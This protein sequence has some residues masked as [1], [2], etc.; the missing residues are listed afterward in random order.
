MAFAPRRRRRRSRWVLVGVILSLVAL[1]VNAGVASR[2]DDP[3]KRLAELAYVDQ[4]H[5]HVEAS[6]LRGAEVN[7]VREDATELGRDGIRRKLE[8]VR[9][10]TATDL[11]AMRAIEPPPDL[12]AS[13]HL[14]VST[15]VLRARATSN[16]ASALSAVLGTIRPE[17]AVDEL[18]K[19]GEELI[20]ADHTY[21]VFVEL[22]VV[23][24]TR[25]PL[26]P[27]STW[28]SDRAAWERPAVS[29][30]VSALRASAMPTPVHDLSLLTF[31]TDPRPVAT[32]GAN[33]V[34]PLMKTLRVEVV[35]ANTGNAAEA[36]VPVVA[37]L[38]GPEGQLDTARQFVDLAPGQ[39]RAVALGGLRPVPGGPSNL[40]V[41]VGPVDGEG[42]LDDNQ[43]SM[44]LVLRG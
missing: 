42:G 5:P 18:T 17:G 8:R 2:S 40:T 41:L 33:A 4:V 44:S 12:V 3:A 1:L 30:F 37:T 13:H 14:L 38:T 21:R 35:V 25:G 11:R 32:E 22:V 16:I 23:E 34:L 20:A 29:A 24:G 39:R 36:G 6:N 26:L 43:R 27:E 19:A 7:Q 28:I 10:G 31:T 15:M 9:R